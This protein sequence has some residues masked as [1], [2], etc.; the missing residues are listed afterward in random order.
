MILLTAAG[1]FSWQAL[2]CKMKKAIFFIGVLIA[3][4]SFGE[5]SL[6]AGIDAFNA[7]VPQDSS[8]T[9][10]FSPL[11]FEL[12]CCVFAEALDPIGRANVSEKLSVK[13]DFDGAYAPIFESFGN[14]PETNRIFFTSA[15]TIGVTDI[16]KV[17][18]DFKRRVFEMSMNA[19]I[20]R[21]WPLKGAERWFQAKLDGWMEDFVMPLGKL[22]SHQYSVVDAAVISAY[23][24]DDAGCVPSE[25]NFRLNG[26]ELKKIPFITFQ[27]K[28]DFRRNK[29]STFIRVPLRGESYLYLMMP[30]DEGN[31]LAPLR[32]KIAG[33]SIHALMLE[34]IDPNIKESGSE[35]CE[36]SLPKF[37]FISTTNIAKSFDV[38]GI[39]E[40]ELLYLYPELISRSAF[41]SV[42]FILDKGN[43][44][45]DLEPLSNATTKM[46]F[47]RPFL[48]FVHC[49][50]S[51]TIP[52][53][54]QFTGE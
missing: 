7:A 3:G 39:Q 18:A 22:G 17:N 9:L 32:K 2:V 15:R 47:N 33:D 23:L 43:V 48:F 11:A 24:P 28:V 29:E 26:G 42:R 36:I 35:V 54:G 4:A 44:P 14:M 21:I 8:N 1:S 45:E 31:S 40:K 34:P 51:N 25:A 10:A 41:Q 20:S 49:P 12:D 19:S 37:D 6:K 13:T 46:T 52:V 53:I 38:L 16:S 50:D 30:T 5:R 27:A